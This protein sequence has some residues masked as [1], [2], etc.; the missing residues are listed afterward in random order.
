MGFLLSGSSITQPLLWL[1]CIPPLLWFLFHSIIYIIITKLDP[2]TV[3]SLLNPTVHNQSSPSLPF[4]SLPF[5]STLH[6]PASM[7]ADLSQSDSLA[8]LTLS[9]LVNVKHGGVFCLLYGLAFTFS[10]SFY[11]FYNPHLHPIILFIIINISQKTPFKQAETHGGYHII[12]EEEKEAFFLFEGNVVWLEDSSSS[13]SWFIWL[14]SVVG[15]GFIPPNFCFQKSNLFCMV[16]LFIDRLRFADC[17]NHYAFDSY[18]N[19]L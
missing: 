16:C 13:S 18:T 12:K 1:T 19:L 2:I 9:K 11:F 3:Q 5:I 17:Y 7:T 6:T 8:L 4:P 14:E 15:P 10:L